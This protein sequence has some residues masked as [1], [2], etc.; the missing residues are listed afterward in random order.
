MRECSH[1]RVAA[2]RSTRPHREEWDDDDGLRDLVP[3]SGGGGKRL[4]ESQHV[5]WCESVANPLQH[6]PTMED[7]PQ[8]WRIKGKTL[9][10][11]VLVDEGSICMVPWRS[12][13]STRI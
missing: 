9:L 11:K 1:G 13:V 6:P 8:G 3:D 10:D 4:S 2:E 12:V 5:V 7:M